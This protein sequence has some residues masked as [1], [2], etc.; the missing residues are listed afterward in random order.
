MWKLM[1][2]F[3]CIALR[4]YVI[5]NNY[6]NIEYIINVY[7]AWIKLKKNCFFRS[8]EYLIRAF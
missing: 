4:F 8:F 6:I 2:N 5:K 3:I 7:N 1:Y